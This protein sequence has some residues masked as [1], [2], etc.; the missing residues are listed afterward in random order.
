M[1][2]S[3]LEWAVIAAIAGLAAVIGLVRLMPA[4]KPTARGK[5]E[6]EI[7]MLYRAVEAYRLDM[8]A[9]PTQAQG[10]QA[11]VTMPAG[12]PHGDHYR[13]G[14]YIARL[15]NDPW[16]YPYHYRIPGKR[17]QFD[18]FSL[19]ADGRPGGVGEDADF[20]VW[21]IITS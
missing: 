7:A 18:V 3:P 13:K 14:G 11:L 16:G 5:A 15:P 8:F 6:A 20:G 2:L 10:L 21:E 17:S 9:Y 1:S 19:G 4:A 12:L